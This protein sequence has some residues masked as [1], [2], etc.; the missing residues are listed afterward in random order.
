[1]FVLYNRLPL[2]S[3][4]VVPHLKGVQKSNNKKYMN[5]FGTSVLIYCY[6]HVKCGILCA[7]IIKDPCSTIKQKQKLGFYKKYFQ[8]F[9]L[10]NYFRI[11]RIT[12]S[13]KND[14]IQSAMDK[15]MHTFI[16]LIVMKTICGNICVLQ[17]RD[18]LTSI[19]I[20]GVNRQ[21]GT[22]IKQYYKKIISVVVKDHI[23]RGKSYR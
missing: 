12:E 23:L 11:P 10:Y 14:Q 13:S 21:R 18:F 2:V 7:K 17:K 19:N 15:H 5:L 4:H 22:L 16:F 3:T 6:K 8:N 1:M 9:H 20:G